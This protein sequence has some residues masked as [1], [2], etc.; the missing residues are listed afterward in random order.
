MGVRGL[1][2]IL[3]RSERK[4]SLDELSGNVLAVDLSGWVCQASTYGKL[5]LEIESSCSKWFVSCNMC[6]HVY[7]RVTEEM[8]PIRSTSPTY[9]SKHIF[10]S[11]FNTPTVNPLRN[12]FFRIHHLYC[13]GAS[14]VF[15]IDGEVPPL[16]K[17]VMM[18]RGYDSTRASFRLKMEKVWL[19]WQCCLPIVSYHF[20]HGWGNLGNR[21]IYYIQ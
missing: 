16:K 3:A 15:V 7:L 14:L 13:H 21:L 8:M 5:N 9:H 20:A 12:L 11:T 6:M 10:S 4:T 17:M 19:K 1:W 18:S 2:R